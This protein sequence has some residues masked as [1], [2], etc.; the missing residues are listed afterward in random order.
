MVS[1]SLVPILDPPRLEERMTFESVSTYNL[2]RRLGLGGMGE[3][4]LAERISAG[5]HSQKVA[6]KFLFDA[7]AG[8]TLAREALRMSH[9]S[10]DNIVPFVDSGRDSGGRYFV[11]MSYV[12]GT[13]LEGLRTL[14]G[15]TPKAVFDKTAT[16]RIPDK[17]VGFIMFLVLRALGYA[18]EY[19][20]DDGSIGIIHR[21]VSPGNILID[22]A[23]GFVKLTDFGVAAQKS[24]TKPKIEIAGKVPYM[25][26]EVLTNGIVDARADLYSLGVVFYEL[27][28]GFNPNMNTANIASVISA[29]TSVMLSFERPLRP[30]HEVVQGIDPELSRIVER[31]LSTD[32]TD[33]YRTAEEVAAELT[34]FL[35]ASGVGPNTTSVTSYIKLMKDPGTAP[36]IRDRHALPFLE[37]EDGTPEVRLPWQLTEEAAEEIAGGRTPG[38]VWA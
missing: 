23:K 36:D 9:L 8:R 5:N 14:V 27:L 24:E 33:R 21:D 30:P 1:D 26:P 11:A 10:H 19:T 2:V 18:H 22:E 15:L 32:P 38:R 13:D 17:I 12:K 25:A 7:H 6:I 3:V 31:L 28:T 4:W 35:Y 37:T 20:F 16:L 29:I 34:Y